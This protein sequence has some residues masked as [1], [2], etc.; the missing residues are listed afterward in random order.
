MRNDVDGI[1]HLASGYDAVGTM[2]CG[3]DVRR[4]YPVKTEHVHVAWLCTA[5]R[6]TAQQMR[7]G[8]DGNTTEQAP[9]ERVRLSETAQLSDQH[10][11][12]RT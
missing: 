1:V 8:H 11:W 2:L 9:S 4:W 3:A 6:A 5:C 10:H 12:P 7:G